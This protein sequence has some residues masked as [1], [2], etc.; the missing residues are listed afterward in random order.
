LH[1]VG[2]ALLMPPSGAIFA[3]VLL[4]LLNVR[5]ALAEE[6]FLRERFGASYDAYCAKVPRFLPTPGAQVPSAGDETHWGQAILGELYFVGAFAVVAAL[7]WD[8]NATPLKRDL[9]ICIGVALVARAFLPAAAAPT[10][11]SSQ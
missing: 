8:F 11:T 9:V 1:T 2:I 6:P 3:I 4:W 5:L 10:E 7:G